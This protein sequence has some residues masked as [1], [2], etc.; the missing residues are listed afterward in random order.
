MSFANLQQVEVKQGPV[1]RLLGLADVHVRSAGGGGGDEHK[2]K[3]GDSM[4]LAVFHGVD[5]AD[6]IRD[7]ILARLKSFREAG[8]GDPDEHSSAAPGD[9]AALTAA[10]DLLAEVRAWRQNLPG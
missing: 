10:R 5:N 1:Q 4:H 9:I 6:E 8:L 7:L 2:G 3:A